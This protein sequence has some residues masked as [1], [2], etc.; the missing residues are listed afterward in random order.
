MTCNRTVNVPSVWVNNFNIE[1]EYSGLVTRQQ[2]VRMCGTVENFVRK[3]VH[4]CQLVCT[5]LAFVRKTVDVV[6]KCYTVISK[7]F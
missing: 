4:P 3:L 6:L 7:H 5:H 2:D 1:D